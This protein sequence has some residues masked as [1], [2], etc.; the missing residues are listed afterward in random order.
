MKFYRLAFLT[1][2]FT[3]FAATAQAQVVVLGKGQAAVCYEYAY[4][5]NQGSKTAIGTCSEAIDGIISKKDLAST[6]VNRGVLYM[7]SG[8]QDKAAAD[9]L[10]ALDIRPNLTEAHVNYGASLIHQ[11]RYDDAIDSL[12]IALADTDSFTRPT[13]LLNRAIAYDWQEN[14]TSAYRDLKAAL[15]LRPDWEP[16]LKVLSRYDVVTRG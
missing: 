2:G 11:K 6:H 12:N 4:T 9:Y 3:A 5:G 7:R 14:Y 13:A 10:K 16:A 1:L 8:Q 15:A